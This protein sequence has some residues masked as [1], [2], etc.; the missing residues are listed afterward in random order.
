MKLIAQVKLQ[1]NPEQMALLQ[2]TLR[3]ANAACN[4]LAGIAWENKVFGQFALH[5][6]AYRQT[7]DEF[8]A[9]TAQVIVRCIARVAA[10]YKLSRK[11]TCSFQPLSAIAYDDR[12]LRWYVDKGAVSIWAVG[13]RLHLPFVCGERQKQMLQTR[14]GESDLVFRDGVFYLYAVC[15]VEETPVNDPVD[16]LGVD[17]GLVNLTV[18]SDGEVYSGTAVEENRRKFAHRRRNLQR[19][20]TK[21]AKRKLKKLS[22]KQAR[23]Q[24]NTNHCISKHVVHKAQDTKR[25]IALE[26]L[27]GIR[28]RTTFRRRQRARHANWAFYQLRQFIEYKAKRDGVTVILVDPRNTSR[29]CPACGHIDKANRRTQDRFSCIVCGYSAPADYNAAGNIRSRA[30]AVV[31]RPMVSAA[32]PLGTS[33]RL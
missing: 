11:R 25:G 23:F 7:R 17:L 13:G 24:Q 19:N 31:N 3:Q 30:R 16:F 9:L 1:A 32:S 14:Q 28:T 10:A 20:G 27:T 33:P 2:E 29:E 26:D 8:P 12:I 21:A 5:K 6:L 15:N 4:F 22:G 18:D